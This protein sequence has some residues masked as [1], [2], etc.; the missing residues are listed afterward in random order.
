[1]IAFII[2]TYV[3]TALYLPKM[4]IQGG[5]QNEYFLRYERNIQ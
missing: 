5:K 3:L 1:M 2:T 4:D